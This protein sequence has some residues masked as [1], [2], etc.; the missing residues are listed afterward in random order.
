M[1]EEWGL[2]PAAV[3][4][5]GWSLPPMPEQQRK[6]G[7]AVRDGKIRYRPA[8]GKGTLKLIDPRLDFMKSTAEVMTP[9]SRPS[10]Q[11]L[12]RKW[13]S[14]PLL[15]EVHLGDVDQFRAADQPAV[16]G[17]Y[18]GDAALIA[19]AITAL[20]E[21]RKTNPSQA[22]ALVAERAA[23]NSLNQKQAR[24]RKAIAKQWKRAQPKRPK[25]QRTAN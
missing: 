6:F 25:R 15:I 20:R 14:V 16:K 8:I 1:D 2:I 24:L 13:H 12:E 17:R 23:G 21:G 4:R 10:W 5:L 9:I 11:K 7:D 22:A 18:P 19:E 3:S